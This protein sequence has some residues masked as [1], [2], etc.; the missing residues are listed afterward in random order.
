[1]MCIIVA[2][3]VGIEHNLYCEAM[4]AELSKVQGLGLGVRQTQNRIWV[5]D[6]DGEPLIKHDLEA[7]INRFEFYYDFVKP[8]VREDRRFHAQ[9]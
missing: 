3:E 5:L 9:N 7:R 8:L 4:F 1:M 6:T 2:V